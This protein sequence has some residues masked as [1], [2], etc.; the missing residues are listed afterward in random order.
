MKKI[1]YE[2]LQKV[3]SPEEMKNIKAGSTYWVL[4]AG[5]VQI[6]VEANSCDEAEWALSYLLDI[7]DWIAIFGEGC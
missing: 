5:N 7:C 6:P 4:C 1:S 2:R 3:L